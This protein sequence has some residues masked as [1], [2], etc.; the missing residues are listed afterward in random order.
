MID[1][2]EMVYKIICNNICIFVFWCLLHV[3]NFNIFTGKMLIGSCHPT[4]NFERT[5]NVQ[6]PDQE[7]KADEMNGRP[8]AD[9]ETDNR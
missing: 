6:P 9:V 3:D 7:P 2:Q 8:V 1:P 5:L 4:P